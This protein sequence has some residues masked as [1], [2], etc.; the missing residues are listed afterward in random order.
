MEHRIALYK[1]GVGLAVP[2]PGCGTIASLPGGFEAT[3]VQSDENLGNPSSCSSQSR[4]RSLKLFAIATSFCPMFKFLIH[5]NLIFTVFL[6]EACH[7]GIFLHS[8]APEEEI[9]VWD[10]SSIYNFEEFPIMR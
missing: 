8:G 9:S 10:S 1:Q 6:V 5:Y 7:S 2:C 4:P 3:G